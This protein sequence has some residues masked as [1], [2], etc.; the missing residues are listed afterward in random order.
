MSSSSFSSASK[1]PDVWL[2]KQLSW[3][4]RHSACDEGLPMKSDGYVQV[5]D[6]LKRPDMSK[7]TLADINRVVSESDKQRYETKKDGNGIVWIRASQGHSIKD[8]DLGLK[9]IDLSN[10]DEYPIVQ[11]GTYAQAWDS[12]KKQGLSKCSRNHIHFS[13][14]A[15]AISGARADCNVFIQ[16]DLAN[17][18]KEGLEFYESA[19]GVILCSG[20]KNGFLS[21]K[22]FGKVFDKSGK[23]LLAQ[24]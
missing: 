13:K 3:L 22:F 17:A 6:I 24:K 18:L 16:I 8:I 9:R 19:N 2:S 20:D 14:G 4:L 12:I 1:K 21:P 11:H 10:A 23:D 7:F 5:A 15:G